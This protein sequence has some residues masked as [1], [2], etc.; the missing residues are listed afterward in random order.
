HNWTTFLGEQQPEELD[1]EKKDQR[2][3]TKRT[4][5]KIALIVATVIVGVPTLFTL[6]LLVWDGGFAVSPHQVILPGVQLD[7]RTVNTARGPV[8]YDLYG[9]QGPVV[10]SLHAGLG[11]ADQGR[12]FAS[13][14]QGDGFR[15]LSPSR[16]G[17]LGTPLSSGKTLEEQADLFAA[18]LD[19]L[20]IEKVGVLSASAAG[21][22]A[23][24]FVAR[25]PER[26]WG[27]VA[28]DTV[29][30]PDPGGTFGGSGLQTA[31]LNTIGQKLAKLTAQISLQ[32]VVTQ[33]LDETTKYSSAQ[34]E[35]RAAYIMN[36]PHMRAFFEALFNT[37][38]PYDKRTAGTNNDAEQSQGMQSFSFASI[39][40]PS[41]IVHG[42]Q[43]GDVPFADGVYAAEH[44]PGAQHYW[45]E[46][47]GH[48]DFW[49]SPD[50]AK[51]QDAVRTFLRQH[52]PGT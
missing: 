12:L 17:Y 15:I 7:L 5:K 49:L 52:T 51:A 16:P 29:S 43:D 19:T 34:K 9:S 40:A 45:M 8:Q 4:I 10:L 3:T 41:L 35:Q 46:N 30:R 23:Y 1:L 31:F 28:I 22:V 18:L 38:F 32:T 11:G 36:T 20:K 14:L 50:A 48:L 47:G 39:T 27:L 44:I 42:T 24:T 21:P 6:G 13:F 26:V 37:T 2:R 33:T 25:H